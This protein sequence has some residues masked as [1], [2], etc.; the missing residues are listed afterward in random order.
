MSS[1]KENLI[2]KSKG[3]KLL[4]KHFFSGSE[5]DREIVSL[6]NKIVLQLQPNQSEVFKILDVLQLEKKS[7]LE[8]LNGVLKYYT[9]ECYNYQLAFYEIMHI[10]SFYKGRRYSDYRKLSLKIKREKDIQVRDAL[11]RAFSV[12]T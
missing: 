4:V 11:E 1:E 2:Y 5:V 6:A 12:L 3:L 7:A 9:K 8:F 10:L